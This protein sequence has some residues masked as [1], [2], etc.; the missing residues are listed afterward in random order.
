MRTEKIRPPLERAT[1][2]VVPQTKT[3][4]SEGRRCS[5]LQRVRE[6][7]QRS[8]NKTRCNSST[9]HRKVRKGGKEGLCCSR[10]GKSIAEMMVPWRT[11]GS[12]ITVSEM[13]NLK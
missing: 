1:E 5:K 12:G 2:Q 8:T 11:D 3:G 13:A 4:P 6:M 7:T 10:D 9:G